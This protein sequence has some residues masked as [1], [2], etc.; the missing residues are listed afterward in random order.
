LRVDEGEAIALPGEAADYVHDPTGLLPLLKRHG[1]ILQVD[2]GELPPDLVRSI[3]R[4][5]AIGAGKRLFRT[6]PEDL[7]TAMAVCPASDG[8]L[9]VDPP[10]SHRGTRHRYDPSD[11]GP[12]PG[13][14]MHASSIFWVSAVVP[15][16]IRE[17]L[18]GAVRLRC[19][20]DAIGRH[21]VAA[22]QAERFEITQLECQV[23]AG[24]LP[25]LGTGTILRGIGLT[26]HQAPDRIGDLARRLKGIATARGQWS[27]TEAKAVPELYDPRLV[28]CVDADLAIIEQAII[29]GGDM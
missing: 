14:L 17:H 21:L 25:A 1:L 9:A 4:K 12:L 13:H 8:I 18:D 19:S 29:Q 23:L 28:N 11:C 24:R 3:A 20:S 27:R 22:A 16:A 2:P 15:E 10:R 6:S 7:S 5:M 26:D